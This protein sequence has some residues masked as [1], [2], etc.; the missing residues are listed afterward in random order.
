MF[1]T[2]DSLICHS[3][4]LLSVVGFELNFYLGYYK[5]KLISSIFQFISSIWIPWLKK[6]DPRKIMKKSL[7]IALNQIYLNFKKQAT[8]KNWNQLEKSQ[9]VLQLKLLK[10]WNFQNVVRF[11]IISFV[12]S[13]FHLIQVHF[14]YI[15]FNWAFLCLYQGNKLPREKC[16][17][18]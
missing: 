4:I 16:S 12:L 3:R 10:Y 6:Y 11:C 18:N 14:K 13:Y 9:N 8:L 7:K 15:I 1:V 17:R 5:K 2:N